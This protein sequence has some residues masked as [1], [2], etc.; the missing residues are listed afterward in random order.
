MYY[1]SIIIISFNWYSFVI[2]DSFWLI[3]WIWLMGGFWIWRRKE[4]EVMMT[5]EDDDMYRSYGGDGDAMSAVYAELNGSI[6]GGAGGSALGHRGQPHSVPSPYQLNTYAEIGEAHRIQRCRP[7]VIH[8]IPLSSWFP[9]SYGRWISDLTMTLT[10]WRG[11][12]QR[13]STCVVC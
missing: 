12:W 2:V 11:R 9:S 8:P 1:Y 3:D 13:H 10:Q 6:A 4:N 5:E 7:L